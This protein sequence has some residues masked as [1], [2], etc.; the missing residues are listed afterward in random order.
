L[1]DQWL[2]LCVINWQV[3]PISLMEEV[4]RA[5]GAIIRPQYG[6]RVAGWRMEDFEQEAF[7]SV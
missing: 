7:L 2:T 6:G 5:G 1:L 4:V 3:L